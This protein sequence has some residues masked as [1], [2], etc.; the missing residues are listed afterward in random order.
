MSSGLEATGLEA[1]SKI[2]EQEGLLCTGLL[3]YDLHMFL[4]PLMYPY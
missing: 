4:D 3:N 1:C 2:A